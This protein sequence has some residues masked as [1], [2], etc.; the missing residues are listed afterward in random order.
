MIFAAGPG[1]RLKPLT[2]TRPKALVAI[3][4][5]PMLEHL[6]LKLK[7]AGFDEI[8]INIHH[9]GDQIIDF[10]KANNDFGLNIHIS[11]E[12][13]YLL[14][15][16]GGLK[17]AALF[18]RGNEPFLVHNVD[19]LSDV[20]L[21]AFCRSHR[22]DTL[23]TL[24]VSERPTSRHLLFDSNNRLLGWSNHA[25]GEIKSFFP[26]F[27]SRP[28]RAYA[29]GGIHVVSPTLF[30]RMEEWTGKFSIID[31]YIAACVKDVIAA[32]PAE[33]V[34]LYDAGKYESLETTL[35]QLTFI[36]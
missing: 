13:E 17:H 4:G 12:Q 30:D 1:T 19:I 25:T 16:G 6:L 27:A 10:L 26:D 11:D 28:Y 31:F 9:F 36:Q 23:A 33:G 24:L 29:F 14:D 35:R 3:K 8:V 32:Y 7:K 2:D 22:Q 34:A 5:K 18:L 21:A 15:T 20:D